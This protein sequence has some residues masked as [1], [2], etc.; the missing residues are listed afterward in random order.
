MVSI[1]NIYFS[2][3]SNILTPQR[4][5][6]H[7]SQFPG[8]THSYAAICSLG[9]LTIH[10]YSHTPMAIPLG[11]I[12][13]QCFAKGQFDILTARVRA[14]TINHLIRGGKLNLLHHKNQAVVMDADGPNLYIT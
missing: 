14:Q 4:A 11:A 8:Y 7:L 2:C 10:T 5:L 13:V 1:H 3:L 6:Q 12:W 9:Q